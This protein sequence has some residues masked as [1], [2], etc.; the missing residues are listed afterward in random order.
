MA[1]L[2]RNLATTAT[3]HKQPFASRNL[4]LRMDNHPLESLQ[5]I[6]KFD[7]SSQNATGTLNLFIPAFD[8]TI[9]IQL[10]L[11]HSNTL[12]PKSAMTINDIVNLSD[13]AYHQLLQHLYD[14][15]LRT[16]DEVGFVD[17]DNST[18]PPQN[19]F[20][21]RL[22]GCETP[23][24]V[25]ILAPYD[26]RHP[27]FL[28]DG[29]NSVEKNVEWLAFR[30][31]EHVETHARMCLLDC[32]PRWDDEHGVTVVIRDGA[33]VATGPYDLAIDEFDTT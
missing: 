24:P 12:L 14:D 30:I 16:R 27:C 25:V 7:G 11:I 8:A 33:S 5:S 19:S 6:I 20:I 29:I 21:G 23:A 10:S 4:S 22:F 26:P 9:E 3:D 2:G 28:E 1:A 32:L 31:N 13:A 18:Q 17:M 15:A